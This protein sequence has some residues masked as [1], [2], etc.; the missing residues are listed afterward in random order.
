[1][2]RVVFTKRAGKQAAAA[3]KWWKRNRNKA[4]HAFDEDLSAFIKLVAAN[5][6][7][8]APSGF[9]RGIRRFLL[10]RIHYYVYY[11]VASEDVVEIVSIWHA[12]RR[13]P[14]L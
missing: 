11:R 10:D 1:M 6:G 3:A 5:A 2:R 9:R 4:P 13:P 12:S 8:G 14:R 7:V